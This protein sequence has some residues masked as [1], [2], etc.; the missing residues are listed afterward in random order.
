MDYDRRPIQNLLY[1]KQHQRKEDIYKVLYD[2]SASLAFSIPFLPWD[3]SQVIPHK[4]LHHFTQK[5]TGTQEVRGL[6]LGHTA[7][8]C[9]ELWWLSLS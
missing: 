8:G 1:V 3:S 4:L 9:E 6:A 2:I 5:D 7:E